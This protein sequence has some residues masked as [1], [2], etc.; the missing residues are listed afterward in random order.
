MKPA[1]AKGSDPLQGDVTVPGDKSISHRALMLGSQCV[2]ESKV[3]GLLAS[4]DVLN[5][6]KALQQLGVNIK[7]SDD[8][9]TV[10]GQGSGSLMPSKHP[11]DLGNSGTGVRLLMGL[12]GAHPFDTTFTG[13]ASL[14]SRPMKRITD[15]LAKMGINASFENED[16]KLPLTIHGTQDAMPIQYVSPVAS[17]QIKSAILLAGINTPGETSVIEPSSSR[18]HTERMLRYLGAEVMEHITED[19]AHEACIRGYP[20]LDAKDMVVPGD[21]SS[22]AFLVVAALLVPRSNITI[23]NISINPLRAGLFE[24]LRD[25]GGDI[26][27]ENEREECGEPVADIRVKASHLKGVE[28]PEKVVPSMIDEYPVLSIAAAFAEGN[29]TMRGL[30]ELRVKES[31]RLQAIADGLTECGIETEIEGDDLTVIGGGTVKSG[32]IKTHMDHRIAMSFLV[33]GLISGQEITVDDV[34]MIQTSF[35]DFIPLMKRLGGRI[36]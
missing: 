24:V 32:T 3:T 35:P 12:L 8:K 23:M 29:T 2:G 13:D 4:E 19:G 22:A 1:V 34:E 5:T 30:K 7:F 33:M 28:V 20:E 11:L 36:D 14:R 15:P 21:P 31:D 6:M 26:S 27:Y 25:M 9:T 18:D 10:K 16:G 17:A